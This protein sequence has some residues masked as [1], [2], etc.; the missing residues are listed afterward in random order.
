MPAQVAGLG[1]KIPGPVTMIDD[2]G[3]GPRLRH[4][5]CTSRS[6]L[7]A[8]RKTSDHDIDNKADHSCGI[9]THDT[10]HHYYCAQFKSGGN[11]QE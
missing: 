1:A 4:D 8:N 3:V 5:V 10:V 7:G 9:E 2:D 11:Q 6:G